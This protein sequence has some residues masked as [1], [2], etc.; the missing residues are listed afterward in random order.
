MAEFPK[1]TLDM[2]RQPIESGKVTISRA[3]STVT[4]P[5]KFILIGAMNPCPCGYLGDR[6]HY[7]T[8]SPKQVNAYQNRISGPILDRMDILLTLSPVSFE[9]ETTED[10]E[11]SKIIRDRVIQ[12]RDIQY[13]RYQSEINNARATYDQLLNGEGLRSNQQKMLQQWSSKYHLS[14]RVEIKIIS[15]ARTISDLQGNEHITDEALWEAMTLTTDNE[16]TSTTKGNGT[17]RWGEQN[18]S[19]SQTVFII[20]SVEEIAGIRYLKMMAIFLPS[21]IY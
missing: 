9:N 15:L 14:N 2:L 13:E 10:Q 3:A 4:Y 12:A 17:I 20:S 5:S 7:C 1:K 6:H 21:F 19:L 18:E 8:C 16:C 11:T